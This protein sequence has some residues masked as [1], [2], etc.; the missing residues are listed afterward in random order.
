[1]TEKNNSMYEMYEEYKQTLKKSKRV[2]SKRQ[3]INREIRENHSEP[4]RRSDHIRNTADI[5]HWNSMIG[6]LVEDMKCIEMYLDFND[7]YYLH[8]QYFDTKSMI[9]NQNSYEGEIP[10][11]PL[12]YE[13]VDGVEEK[14]CEIEFQEEIVDLL[15][16]VLTE[17][18]KQVVN[19]YYFEEKTQ[20]QIGK[21]LDLSRTRITGLLQESIKTLRKYVKS[22]NLLDF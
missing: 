21:M 12:Y 8:K 18:Q 7:R 6:E 11:D 20:E 22:S 16:K 15:D 19:L 5:T 17:R 14:I 2:L 10:F 3:R 13:C 9:Y 1:M 4:H